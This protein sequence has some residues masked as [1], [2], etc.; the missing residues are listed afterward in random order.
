MVQSHKDRDG[1][2]TFVVFDQPQEISSLES[3]TSQRKDVIGGIQ[4]KFMY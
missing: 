1:A 4:P 3:V 2:R